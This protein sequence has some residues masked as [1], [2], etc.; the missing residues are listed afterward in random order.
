MNLARKLVVWG[1][2]LALPICGASSTLAALLGSKHFHASVAVAAPPSRSLPALADFRRSSLVTPT[3]ASGHA[4]S[5]LSRHPHASVDDSVIAL[6]KSAGSDMLPGTSGSG[7][8]ADGS[9]ALVLAVFS[10]TTIWQ[11]DASAC[12]WHADAA[13]PLTSCDLRR[14]ERPPRT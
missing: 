5:W 10:G 8:A 12:A 9:A 11:L 7:S 14:L 1:L 3:P 4:H 2:M 6:D 13:S